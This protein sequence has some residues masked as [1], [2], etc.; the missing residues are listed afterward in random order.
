[1]DILTNLFFLKIKIDLTIIILV[2]LLNL[3]N[4]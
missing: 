2:L 1:M 3:E 4:S